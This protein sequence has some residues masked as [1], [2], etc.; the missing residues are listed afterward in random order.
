MNLQSDAIIIQG[1]YE[2]LAGLVI[3]IFWL[4]SLEWRGRSNSK[5]ISNLE[6]KDA[7]IEKLRV[8]VERIDAKLSVLLP[9]YD[10]KQGK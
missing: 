8:S 6:A 3:T 9:D 7:E 5:R 4:A 2:A 1:F 10:G